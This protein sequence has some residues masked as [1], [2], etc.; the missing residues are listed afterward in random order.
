MLLFNSDNQLTDHPVINNSQSPRLAP[1]ENLPSLLKLLK[2][3][4]N[5]SPRGL[6]HCF[7]GWST[8]PHAITKENFGYEIY[9]WNGIQASNKAREVAI[10]K[11]RDFKS[12]IDGDTDPFR[13]VQQ[14]PAK[15]YTILS[16]LFCEDIHLEDPRL[17]NICEKN[18]FLQCLTGNK[19]KYS[20][21]TTPRS[22]QSPLPSPRRESPKPTNSPRKKPRI[23]VFS[24]PLSQV[25]VPQIT[26]PV[27]L[28]LPQPVSPHINPIIP[29]LQTQPIQPPTEVNPENIQTPQILTPD[30]NAPIEAIKPVTKI[31]RLGL[32]EAKKTDRNEVKTDRSE[33][34]S[35]VKTD[36]S[37]LSQD[38]E[39]KENKIDNEEEIKNE[40]EEVKN[41][42]WRRN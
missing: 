32:D 2:S 30:N 16:S 10:A 33:D 42:K 28:D 12:K 40:N 41:E 24:V 6:K 15:E 22:G 5:L 11:G 20:P 34:K 14:L 35:D 1:N 38:N 4:E 21:R 23:P 8:S 19:P 13:R 7:A 18:H 9:L 3:S 17:H 37:D 27:Q 31:P 26:P 36:R 29:L 25:T 39:N